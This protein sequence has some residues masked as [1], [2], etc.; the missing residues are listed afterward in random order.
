MASINPYLNFNGNCEEA[1][2]F[3]KSVLGG[4]FTAFQRFGEIHSEDGLAEGE[5]EKIMHVAL[6]IDQNTVLMGSD[7][8]EAMGKSTVGSNF[9][10]SLQAESEAEATQL[11]NGLAADG[12]V[13][14]PLQQAPWGA[15]FGMLTDKF[16]I[17]WMV[18][19]EHSQ[20]E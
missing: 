14:M 13:T 5:G 6:P 3:Y 1:F 7:S 20:Q 10:L 4:E 15:T 18:N 12:T 17:A 11:F 19:H 9:S 8:L 16:G 2:N